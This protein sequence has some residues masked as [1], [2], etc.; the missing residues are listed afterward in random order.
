MGLDVRKPVPWMPG[1]RMM[2]NGIFS[3]FQVYFSL[4][5]KDQ[6]DEMCLRNTFS[7]FQYSVIDMMRSSGHIYH[8]LKSM[9]FSVNKNVLHFPTVRHTQDHIHHPVCGLRLNL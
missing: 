4:I 9:H 2:Q 1:C 7:I 5:S 6:K 8:H 3:K